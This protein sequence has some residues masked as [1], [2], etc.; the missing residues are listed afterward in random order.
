MGV[1]HFSNIYKNLRGT[2][3]TEI[4]RVVEAMPRFVEE[5]EE[6]SLNQ[7]VTLGE[8]EVAMKGFNKDKSS[9]HDGWPIEFYITSFELIG[10]DLLFSIED[11]QISGRMLE[12]FNSTFLALIPKVDKPQNFDDFQPISLCNC[13]YKITS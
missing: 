10:Q 9:G 12:A 3:I 4:L 2:N 6:E 8:L 7:P 1:R 11:C 5:E 13:V